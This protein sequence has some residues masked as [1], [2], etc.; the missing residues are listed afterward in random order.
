MSKLYSTILF[1]II[2]IFAYSQTYIVDQ[3]VAIVGNNAI[4]QSDIENQ[5]I[6]MQ[7]QKI[8]FDGDAKCAIFEE[9]LIQKF[10][11][12][13]AKIDS[14]EVSD[15]QVDMQVESR[16]KYFME[17]FADQKKMEEYF[18]KSIYEM[19]EDMQDM[20][21]EQLITQQM[22]EK[23]LSDV[24]ITPSE[25]KDYI[26]RLPEDSIPD[27]GTT[28]TYNQ[29][30][31]Y[32]PYQE[33]SVYEI[34][35]KLLDLRKRIVD[36]E[37][38]STLAR[39]YSEDPG[40]SRNGGEIGFLSREELDPEY[41]KIAFGLKT[42]SIST[43]V[44]SQFGFHL[45]QLIEKRGEKANTRHILLKPKAKPEEMQL[46]LS[47]LDSIVELVRLDSLKFEKA[48]QLFSQ[49]KN[50]FLN[51][52]AV[53]NRQT[54]SLEHTFDQIAPADLYAIK[55]L[56]PGEISTPYESADEN[57]KQVFKVIYLKSITSPHKANIDTDYRL[58]QD[59]AIDFK[60]QDVFEK[61]LEEKQKQV[62]IEI[63]SRFKNCNSRIIKLLNR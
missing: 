40:S 48:A 63:D 8:R 61:W 2:Y 44:E 30:C 20:V 16:I 3:V 23:I 46:A 62:V 31:I 14:I 26:S 29:I 11:L 47:K 5:Y 6:Q 37:K 13:Q 39:L 33:N 53:L 12:D 45:I 15:D 34:K 58:L 51:G 57:G 32:P 56:K 52:G 19:K 18:K 35:Q 25:V 17:Y 50:T 38:F 27:V 42:N 55:Q 22:R 60:K 1:S 59:F 21:K 9:L 54:N 7:A 36:G 49:D 28:I 4:L 10:L 43:I 41:A 24:S